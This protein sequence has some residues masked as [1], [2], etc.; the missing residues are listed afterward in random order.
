MKLLWRAIWTGLLLLIPV[1]AFA[2]VFWLWP[3]HTDSARPRP[4]RQLRL[5]EKQQQIADALRLHAEAFDGRFPAELYGD[6]LI[7]QVWRQLDLPP[8]AGHSPRSGF[9]HLATLA[10]NEPTFQY[11]GE[12]VRLGDRGRVLLCWS[13][14]QDRN[15][16]ILGDLTV[17]E[18]DGSDLDALLNPW[19]DIATDCVVRVGKASGVVVSSDGLIVTAC[20]VVPADMDSVHVEYQDGRCVVAK[21]LDYSVRLDI[22]LLKCDVEGRQ[23]YLACD[24]TPTKSGDLLWA[25]GFP[26]GSEACRIR[27]ASSHR[28]VLDELITTH[29]SDV[30]G[31]DSGG[32]I[33]DQHGRLAG[34]IL[35]PADSYRN[36]LR[37]ASLEGITKRWPELLPDCGSALKE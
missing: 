5:S 8:L 11:F 16:V 35:G 26:D 30:K 10:R 25:I 6:R 23:P 21:L 18:V 1:G 37:A 22:A 33:L 24:A 20:H 15:I 2:C 3:E 31:G 9:G 12:S 27:A 32:A 29:G 34:V 19:H 36:Y 4:T 13:P 17:R 28:H 7:A 14:G